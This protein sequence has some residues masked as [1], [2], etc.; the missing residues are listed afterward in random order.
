MGS[1]FSDM[2]EFSGYFGPKFRLA[3]AIVKG[4]M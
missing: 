1:E 2:S 3:P 4:Q